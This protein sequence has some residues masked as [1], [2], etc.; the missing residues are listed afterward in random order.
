MKKFIQYVAMV[1]L[2]FGAVLPYLGM[3]VKA[4]ENTEASCTIDYSANFNVLKA[5][6][7]DNSVTEEDSVMVKS[8]YV[9]KE[10]TI[11]KQDGRYTVDITVPKAFTTWYRGFKVE[12][13]GELKEAIKRQKDKEE[14]EVYTFAIDQYNNP[15][16]AWVDIYVKLEKPIPFTYDNRYT[17]YLVLSNVTESKRVCEETPQPKQKEQSQQTGQTEQKEQSQQTKQTEVKEQ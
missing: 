14:N 5:N 4:E 1:L 2:I 10:A 8:G 13:G 16:R 15:I 17:V 11:K 9:K 6:P 12:S 7:Q 3:E